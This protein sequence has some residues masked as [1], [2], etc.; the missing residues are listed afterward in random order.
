MKKD[1]TIG[2]ILK[3]ERNRLDLSQ[4]EASD[5]AGTSKRTISNWEADVS[6]P[7]ADHLKRLSNAGFDVNFVVTGK[8]YCGVISNTDKLVLEVFNKASPALQKAALLVL[9]SEHSQ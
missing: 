8:Q 3:L 6:Y 1:L 2:Q 5:I 9:H 7:D 4:Q